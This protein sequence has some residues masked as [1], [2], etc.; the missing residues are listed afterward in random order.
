MELQQIACP[1]SIIAQLFAPVH[2][3]RFHILFFSYCEGNMV[4]ELRCLF[5]D[6]FIRN[7]C[8][9]DTRNKPIYRCFNDRHTDC[10][11]RDNL[12]GPQDELFP[13]PFCSYPGNLLLQSFA[14]RMPLEQVHHFFQCSF[15]FADVAIE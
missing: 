5:A 3:S 4:S 2:Y 6:Q 14:A 12:A 11:T 9:N 10:N 8:Q 13:H 7:K 15:A 1:L